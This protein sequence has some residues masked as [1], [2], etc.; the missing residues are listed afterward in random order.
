MT[1]KKLATVICELVNAR[2]PRNLLTCKVRKATKPYENDAEAQFSLLDPTHEILVYVAD[3]KDYV[4]PFNN[5]DE[6]P[7]LTGYVGIDIGNFYQDI[8]STTED[9]HVPFVIRQGTKSMFEKW[10]N[11]NNSSR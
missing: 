9:F 5:F 6:T 7:K 1:N 8:V 10:E 3:I 4:T 11:E 2:K